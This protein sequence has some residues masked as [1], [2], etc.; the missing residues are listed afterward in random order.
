MKNYLLLMVC[1]FC[2]MLTMPGCSGDSEEGVPGDS[3]P[4]PE[5]TDP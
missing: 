5:Y 4:T 3:T 2:L 1:L